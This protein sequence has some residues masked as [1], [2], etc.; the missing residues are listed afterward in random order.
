MREGFLMRAV[1][2]LILVTAWIPSAT[3]LAGHPLDE[4]YPVNWR[5]ISFR[6]ALGE[7]AGGVGHEL[8]T[9]L[10][11]ISNAVY[12]LRLVTSQD[13]LNVREYLDIIEEEIYNAS[14]IIHELL[15]Y[16]RIETTERRPIEVASLVATTVARHPIP[17]NVALALTIP[18]DLPR[19]AVDARHIGQVLDNLITNACQAMPQGGQLSLSARRYSPDPAVAASGAGI[20]A[21][22]CV[23]ISVTDTGTGISPANMER[24]FEP[25]FTTKAKGIGLGL[26]ICRKLAEANDGRITVASE[27]GIGSTFTLLLPVH[28][29]TP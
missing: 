23:E 2:L 14:N 1:I 15:D 7:L 9:P 19:I 18:Q 16:A 25:L 27:E 3:A 8:R 12:Y 26:A 5:G 21:A 28:E 20:G 24:L 22:D 29:A 4:A 10:G 6:E 13:Q 11:V 17:E